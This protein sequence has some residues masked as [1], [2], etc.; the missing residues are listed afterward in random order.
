MTPRKAA[1]ASPTGAAQTSR[2]SGDE[3]M[4]GLAKGLAIIESFTTYRQAM[5]V[6]EAAAATGSTPAAARRC[7]RTLEDLGYLLY[8][9]KHY[10]PTPRL[11]RL[12]AAYS[13]TAPL[14]VLAQPRLEAVRDQ[15]DESV[16]LA[17]LEGDSVVFI[18]RADAPRIL[19]T[20]V[21]VGSRLPALASSSGRVLM[22]TM[23]DSEIERRLREYQPMRTSPATLVSA[24]AIRDRIERSRRDGFEITDEEIEVGVRAIAVPVVD[25]AGEV[26]G[27]MVVSVSS[28]RVSREEMV[29]R[30]L[31]ALQAE[32]TRLGATL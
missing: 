2:P 13:G 5:T 20:G 32:A 9:G 23:P 10:R 19:T 26:H 21:R 12:G 22:G 6:T 18:A 11:I 16:S 28:A 1:K 30:L 4:G 15:V 17:V 3:A 7:L 27:A 29:V 31:P 8:D 25:S 24:S 14:P